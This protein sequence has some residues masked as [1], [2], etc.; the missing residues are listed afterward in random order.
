[1]QKKLYR[2]EAD[3]KVAGVCTGLADYFDVDV[4]LV[5]IAFAVATLAG[6]PGVLIYAVLWWIMPEESELHKFKNDTLDIS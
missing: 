5:R 6:G 1:M 2:I 3:K 4:T